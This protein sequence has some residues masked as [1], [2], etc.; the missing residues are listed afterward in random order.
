MAR[1]QSLAHIDLFDD[2]AWDPPDAV[3]TPVTDELVVDSGQTDTG[4][5]LTF[6]AIALIALILRALLLFP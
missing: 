5:E 4:G 2:P 3:R 1:N 6:I